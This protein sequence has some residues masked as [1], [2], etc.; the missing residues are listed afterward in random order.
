MGNLQNNFGGGRAILR[1]RQSAEATKRKINALNKIKF[2][3]FRIGKITSQKSQKD[4]L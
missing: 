3:N 1:V 4:K 2:L